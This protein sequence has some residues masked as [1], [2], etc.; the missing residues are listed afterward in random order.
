MKDAIVFIY[1]DDYCI[2]SLYNQLNDDIIETIRSSSRNLEKETKGNAGW[3]IFGV[4][5]G[6]K[7]HET[8]SEQKKIVPS[9]DKKIKLL[10]N[11]YKTETILIDDIINK[12][13]PFTES[14]YFVG[15]ASFFLTKIYNG[16]TGKNILPNEK[17][18]ISNIC[19]DEDSVIE[20]DSGNIPLVK[21]YSKNYFDSSDYFDTEFFKETDNALRLNMSNNKI[22][23]SIRHITHD[24]RQGKHFNFYI[25]GELNPTGRTNMQEK[26][27]IRYFIIKPFAVWQ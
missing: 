21:Q 9:I 23:K 7:K 4:G 17:S 11:H 24:I 12:N 16:K 10:I 14:K 2:E 22:K 25:F 19:L 8:E 6:R 27:T 5:I 15:K 18:E 26:D 3:K 20:L 13:L 1:R